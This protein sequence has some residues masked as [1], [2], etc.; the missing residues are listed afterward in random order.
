MDL[1]N[2]LYTCFDRV[3]DV[4]DVYKVRFSWY[5]HGMVEVVSFGKNVVSNHCGMSKRAAWWS[6]R[7]LQ[8]SF[9]L[10]FVYYCT[11]LMTRFASCTFRI[12]FVIAEIF[13]RNEYFEHNEV[14]PKIFLK[15]MI[16]MT[17][18]LSCFRF[19]LPRF[20]PSVVTHSK[21]KCEVQNMFMYKC[22]LQAVFKNFF[23]PFQ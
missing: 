18:F 3:L 15:R 11:D 12:S 7:Q 23:H 8:S 4:H 5:S 6:R 17:C 1:L 16:D 9:I 14:A 13:H 22:Q 21:W 19:I 20:I 2:D 10:L